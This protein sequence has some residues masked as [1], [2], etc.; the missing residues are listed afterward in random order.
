M[1]KWMVLISLPVLLA[2]G[3]QTAAAQE[4]P[5][6]RIY[7]KITRYVARQQKLP[8]AAA[9][10]RRRRAAMPTRSVEIK[11]DYLSPISTPQLTPAQQQALGPRL[12]IWQQSLHA[13]GIMHDFVLKILR[14]EEIQTMTAQQADFLTRFLQNGITAGTANPRY[15][16]A[17][18]EEFDH[19]LVRLTLQ[20]APRQKPLY[21][22]ANC[23]TR[24]LFLSVQPTLPG[25]PL[26]PLRKNTF[27]R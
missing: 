14:P 13:H 1:K 18:A 16:P 9:V 26:E 12:E 3:A 25:L 11:W 2:L 5:L 17:K 23:Y 15:V 21:L 6:S 4:N 10:E 7:H 22:I 20:T 8:W 19:Y 24:E 27:L